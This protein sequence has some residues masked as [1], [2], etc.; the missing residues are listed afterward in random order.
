MFV[1][2]MQ[3]GKM[4]L[5]HESKSGALLDMLA[6][7]ASQKL[8]SDPAVRS[9][10]VGRSPSSRLPSK[11]K[12]LFCHGKAMNNTSVTLGE[13][14]S[15]SPN[16]LLKLFADF[17]GDE[18]KR[19]FL[20]TC[21]IDTVNCHQQFS[22]FGSEIKAREQM[23]IHLQSHVSK[24][25]SEGNSTMRFETVESQKR[26]TNGDWK[27]ISLGKKV[28]RTR[29]DCVFQPREP[30]ENDSNIPNKKLCSPISREP[31]TIQKC[32]GL[33]GW[34]RAGGQVSC[35]IY[36]EHNY[37]SLTPAAGPEPGEGDTPA[38]DAE[39][40]FI[41]VFDD[42]MSVAQ[43][44]EIPV[45]ETDKN[46][47]E[48]VA[49]SKQAN[50]VVLVCC[51]DD[52]WVKQLT[53]YSTANVTANINDPEHF[54]SDE[55]PVKN[56]EHETL[57]KEEAV[58]VS[59]MEPQEESLERKKPKGKAKFIG[60][61][62]VEK[63]MAIA[64]IESMKRKGN[65]TECLECRICNPPRVFTALTTLI[66]HYRSHAG[67]K[68]YE[69]RIC[70]SVF[71]RQHSLNYH[72][73]IHSNKTRFTCTDCGR[74][75]RHPSHFKEHRRRHTGESPYECADCTV[76]FK[77]RNT[78]K[79]HM[80][81]RHGK[82]LTT[83]GSVVAMSDDEFAQVGTVRSQVALQ[84][85]KKALKIKKQERFDGNP[86]G[87]ESDP[88]VCVKT[89]AS[90]TQ[91]EDHLLGDIVEKALRQSDISFP[92][93][94]E[95][96]SKVKVETVWEEPPLCASGSAALYSIIA[97][98]SEHESLVEVNP[99]V[100]TLTATVSSNVH[101]NKFADRKLS[102]AAIAADRF[103]FVTSAAEVFQHA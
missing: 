86:G 69:C 91:P 18:M 14:Q 13:L 40:S 37:T 3:S 50:D 81:T 45:Y 72:M 83:T 28:Q 17:D 30:D 70:G 31:A 21:C 97:E 36:R 55:L 6:E 79:R 39:H 66:S 64:M 90:P 9:P 20:Y 53:T 35:S 94:D 24:L 99:L 2:K 1:G 34:D 12:R 16:H 76:R 7:V 89:E 62:K 8:H 88:L 42:T 75:F 23:K 54:V 19:T 38:P 87:L 44:E 48:G 61:S 56:E 5:S 43:Y 80:K 60:Q 63:E 59:C 27:E 93:N 102:V 22:S 47:E 29:K 103:G 4:V 68:P 101:E 95:L 92:G 98:Q 46:L 73:L 49:V 77:T 41:Q 58:I 82:L 78:F 52:N 11:P 26:R 84:V 57:K 32:P 15:L 10:A 96:V 100:H 25:S 67:I 71:T 74:T 51:V 85:P 65:S 33:E